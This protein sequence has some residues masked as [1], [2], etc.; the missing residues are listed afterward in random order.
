MLLWN[1]YVRYVRLGQVHVL[2]SD[3]V[4]FVEMPICS[5]GMSLL[6][7]PV[8]GIPRWLDEASNSHVYLLFPMFEV[9]ATES[10]AV[11]GQ[12]S[13]TFTPAS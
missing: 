12:H 4:R 6:H 3:N 5:F 8:R 10:Y 11:E 7:I 9:L 1:W 13:M 2:I